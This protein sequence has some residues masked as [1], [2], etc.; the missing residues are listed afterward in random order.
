ML[1]LITYAHRYEKEVEPREHTIDS[2]NTLNDYI[3]YVLHSEKHYVYKI[4]CT[5]LNITFICEPPDFSRLF[6]IF[7]KVHFSENHK[8]SETDENR[9]VECEGCGHMDSPKNMTHRLFNEFYDNYYCKDCMTT[10]QGISN[11]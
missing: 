5:N 8:E 9:F 7:A 11:A 1:K 3:E 10:T 4:E 6:I 2:L